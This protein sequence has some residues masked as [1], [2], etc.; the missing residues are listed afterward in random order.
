MD[1][2]KKWF[3]FISLIVLIDQISKILISFFIDPGYP[4]H[5][6][7]SFLRFTYITND[8]IA[9][10][11]NPF[12]NT[13]LLFFLSMVACFFIIKILFDSQNDS[14]FIQFSLCLII[15]GAI[16]NLIDRFFTSFKIMNYSGVI[17]FIDIGFNGYRFY[18]FNFADSFITI[19]II[20]YIASFLFNKKNNAK[21]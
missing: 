3:F 8:G 6:I 20:L 19:G 16:G 14:Y 17:D 21:S 13:M 1:I 5:I 18:V 9:F 11:L 15:G 7:S 12:G 2:R 10:G 4:K